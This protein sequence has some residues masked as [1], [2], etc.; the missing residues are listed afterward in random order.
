MIPDKMS[1]VDLGA[2]KTDAALIKMLSHWVAVASPKTSVWVRFGE[3]RPAVVLFIRGNT[4]HH[5]SI[6]TTYMKAQDYL[7]KLDAAKG[8]PQATPIN[9]A[10]GRVAGDGQA[11]NTHQ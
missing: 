10:N 1:T 4:P 8:I 11:H 9:Q 2:P 5:L 6:P 7:H 3:G